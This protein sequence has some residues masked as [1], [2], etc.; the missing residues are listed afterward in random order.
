MLLGV[1][2][3]RFV[4]Y[5]TQEYSAGPTTLAILVVIKRS[6][7]L[8]ATIG[9]ESQLVIAS[10]PCTSLRPTQE[11]GSNYEILHSIVHNVVSPN[12][13]SHSK[14]DSDPAVRRGKGVDDPKTGITFYIP[15]DS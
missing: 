3:P 6:L 7:P 5:L 15:S 11:A 4:Y 2:K 8:D 1:E 10:L 12:F 14:R 13:D 9:L